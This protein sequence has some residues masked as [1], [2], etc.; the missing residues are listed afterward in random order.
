[1][2]ERGSPFG[3]H[4]PIVEAALEHA[5]K[6]L[7]DGRRRVAPVVLGP[8]AENEFGTL[9]PAVGCAD[10]GRQRHRSGA[11]AGTKTPARRTDPRR[12]DALTTAGPLALAHTRS[13]SDNRIARTSRPVVV[14]ASMAPTLTGRWVWRDHAAGSVRTEVWRWS[15]LPRP[16]TRPRVF[17]AET[18]Y[19][20]RPSGAAPRQHNPV[21]STRTSS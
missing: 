8:L 21:H 14:R 15:R 19:T 6:R 16:A 20:Q 11:P 4:F 5:G 1:M 13:P 3:S 9:S 7:F 2:R 10:L 18:S 12:V 17:I